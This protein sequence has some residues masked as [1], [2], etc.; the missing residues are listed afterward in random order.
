MGANLTQ[1]FSETSA[2]KTLS[3]YPIDLSMS[4][5]HRHDRKNVPREDAPAVDLAVEQDPMMPGHFNL[6]IETQNFEF[7]PENVSS[8]FVMG[9]GH[10]HVFV[11]DVKISRAY[12]KWYHLPRL[13]P[14]NH[15]IRVTLNT[16]NHQEYAVDGETISDSETVTVSADAPR[17]KMDM[18]SSG[19]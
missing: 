18:D 7:A 3:A 8:E 9:E 6:K 1:N 17:M 10:A 4:G 5:L 14:G 12:G 2:E 15:T 19:K 13:D 11:D 16:N